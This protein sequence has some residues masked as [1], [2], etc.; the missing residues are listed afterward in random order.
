MQEDVKVAE[1]A[2]N[3]WASKTSISFADDMAESKEPEKELQFPN[4]W[5]E[6]LDDLCKE[7][8]FVNK[9]VNDDI[10][11]IH[12]EAEKEG[13]LSDC[14]L[15]DGSTKLAGVIET[16]ECKFLAAFNQIQSD[17]DAMKKCLDEIEAAANTMK[18]LFKIHRGETVCKI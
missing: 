9:F 5:N 12:Q 11:K 14:G 10:R 16:D 13:K 17:K 3:I 4:E 15:S 8:P 1:D 7:N 18:E 6:K 2:G